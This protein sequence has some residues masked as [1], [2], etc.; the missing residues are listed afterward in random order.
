MPEPEPT[1]NTHR[2]VIESAT[3]VRMTV[4]AG[5]PLDHCAAVLA[6]VLAD[7]DGTIPEDA[8]PLLLAVLDPAGE[9]AT[10]ALTG[11]GRLMLTDAL[12][13]PDG[14]PCEHP[15]VSHVAEDA[16]LALSSA[17]RLRLLRALVVVSSLL[18]DVEAGEREDA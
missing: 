6:D 17:D 16:A 2:A 13:A 15:A 9:T 10:E 11:V 3:G 7:P 12:T 14:S 5:G 4:L 18:A 8:T 1:P